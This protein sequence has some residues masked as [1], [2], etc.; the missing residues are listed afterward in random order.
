MHF[1]Y[2][3][4]KNTLKIDNFF[5]SLTKVEK[6]G[7]YKFDFEYSISQTY[8]FKHKALAVDV[9]VYSQ[10]LSRE[11]VLT[12]ALQRGKVDTK[13]IINKSQ[14]QVTNAKTTRREQDD[15]LIARRRS[16]ITAYVNNEIIPKL[17]KGVDPNDVQQLVK[18]KIAVVDLAD[19]RR[20]NDDKPVLTYAIPTTMLS[21]VDNATSASLDLNSRLTRIEMLNR[22]LDPS[23]VA[24]MSHVSVPAEDAVQG[25]LR[26]KKTHDVEHSP[27]SRLLNH[28][29]FSDDNLR[30]ENTTSDLQYGQK[31]HILTHEVKDELTI[32]VPLLIPKSRRKLPNG[33]EV[34]TVYVEYRLL[35]P[36][37]GEVIDSVVKTVDLT[38]YVQFYMTPKAPP[39]VKK[40]TSSVSSRVN[41]EI[42][43]TSSNA[44]G[45]LIYKKMF[46]KSVTTFE[47]YVLVGKHTLDDDDKP[48]VISV[49]K[50][51]NSIAIY[52]IVS[53]GETG[54]HGP[55][56]TNV[57]IQPGKTQFKN[58][59]AVALLA[60]ENGV[61]IEVS[62]IPENVVSVQPVVRNVSTK[63]KEYT[64][65]GSPTLID[66]A[67]RISN[68]IVFI[69]K[70]VVD[71]H[72]YEYAF[73]LYHR[74]GIEEIT[75]QKVVDY[76]SVQPGKVDTQIRNVAI[77]NTPD[78]DVK[79]D[80]VFELN[81]S[82]VGIVKD[83]MDRDDISK[84]FDDD[85]K[86]EREFLKS[87]VAHNVQ[88]VDLST[89]DRVD[90]G[91]I[92]N[93]AFSD[94]LFA[95]KNSVTP[96]TVGH[97]YR[98][99][100]YTL[101]RSPETMFET[102]RKKKVDPVTKKPYEFSPSKFLHP[103]V[104]KR[105]VIVSTSGLKT[106]YG[107]DQM[108]YGSIGLSKTLDVS[109]AKAPT[110]II[111]FS[112]TR[113]TKNANLLT[114][115]I[116]GLINKIDHFII[117]KEV[118]GVRT[119]VGKAHSEFEYGNCQFY[120]KL[121]RRDIG[122]LKYVIMAVYNDYDASAFVKSNVVVIE[123]V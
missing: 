89:G 88:R 66:S 15:Y 28:L 74:S 55:D 59:L 60:L 52:R 114:W 42:T 107:Q 76:T 23:Y 43:Q 101:I 70:N 103:V 115:R 109:F 57:V 112:A 118:N 110:N 120:H 4:Q 47:D 97:K 36:K 20:A 113:F 85:I 75:G 2:K 50:P 91:V 121:T 6:N 65:V 31:T 46:K 92:S 95:S 117:M 49:D 123:D 39:S 84:Y 22:G 40:T 63:E 77:T 64:N 90:F 98:Y 102:F 67:V 83:L 122:E 18:K 9:S 16:D 80:I 35:N 58:S 7:D 8:A 61:K 21:S 104:L 108:L 1:R 30:K 71:G 87:L 25:T 32:K 81:D 45:V 54:I 38:K 100:I 62:E 11:K 33:R 96:L 13:K 51:L 82:T 48:L 68:H 79:F 19:L 93:S 24:G 119:I 94:H 26:K 5:A 56:F 27:Q 37:T 111:D 10:L 116:Q 105:G 106:R 3:R 12:N 41:L 44:T 78:L 29:V 99:E 86:R 73:R 14:K 72:A 34:T 17:N 69:D 53:V